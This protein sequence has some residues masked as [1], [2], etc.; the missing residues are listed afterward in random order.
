VMTRGVQR[1]GTPS[2]LAT[3]VDARTAKVIRTE[4]EIQTA[5]GSGQ[6][7]YSG[8]V[9]LQLTLSAGTYQLK[10]PTRGNTYTTDLKNRTDSLW[11]QL[12]GFGC[13]AG[14]LFTSTDNSFGNGTNSNRESAG[15]DAQYGTNVTWDYY[16]SGTASSTPARAR[17]TGSTTATP[18]STPSG[19]A[20]R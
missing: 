19:T 2:R 9:P 4:Q 15:V 1:D 12:F 8:T 7:L 6:S 5:D 20:A 14:T 18:T 17:S 3:Y 11:C 16:K 10:D 13:S